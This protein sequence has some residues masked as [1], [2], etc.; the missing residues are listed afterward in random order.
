[1]KKV[2]ECLISVLAF[3]T[4]PVL[5][6]AADAIGG[7]QI[8]S[9]I[10]QI[11]S[12]VYGGKATT[13]GKAENNSVIISIKDD[14]Q[15]INYAVYSGHSTGGNVLN[16]T[17]TVSED[18][19]VKFYSRSLYAGYLKTT[20]SATGLSINGNKIIVGDGAKITFEG[21][22]SLYAAEASTAYLKDKEPAEVNGNSVSIGVGATVDGSVYAARGQAQ[23]FTENSVTLKG[24]VTG[25]VFGVQ[26]AYTNLNVTT[27]YDNISVTLEN[28][29]VGGS[30]YA[31]DTSQNEK[32]SS[33]DNIY[34]SIT[35]SK[36]AGTVATYSSKP[37][38]V[39]ILE[40][41]GVNEVG[42]VVSSFSTM[43]LNVSD[44]NQ[45]KAVLTGTE[46]GYDFSLSDKTLVINGLDSVVADGS[47]KLV[48]FTHGGEIRFN[49]NT[50][51][52][53]KGVFVDRL[54]QV[55]SQTQ[56]DS[57]TD[58]L[59]IVNGDLM[60][61]DLLI[62]VGQNHANT[63]SKTLA[64]SFLGSIAFVNQG[65]EFIADECIRAMADVAK[66]G[67]L[68]VFGAVHGGTS[69]YDTGSHVDVD[70]VTIATGATTKV[71][72]LL[73]AGFFEAGWASSD[74]HVSGTKGD[75]DHDYYGLGAAVRYNL[76]TPF[77]IDGS[78]RLGW[79]STEFSGRYADASAK[80]D[81]GGL[82]SSIHA[83][84]GYVFGL[85][86]KIAL[87]VYGRYVMTYLE[88]DTTHL[89]T[90]DNEK[91][92][93]DNTMTHAFRLG[94]RVNG[95]INENL[96]WRL[97]LAYERVVDG[98]AESD[99]IVSGTRASLEVPTLEGN[100]GIVEA[101]ITMR[102]SEISP[103]SANIGLKGYAGDREGVS[104]N[105]SVVYTF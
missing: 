55:D 22:G 35:D 39:G 28:A 13:G 53:K 62:S 85:T 1:M 7:T 49:K 33:I 78:V 57:W 32:T 68:S 5:S 15:A 2:V 95:S 12:T 54:W 59:Q 99:V 6:N 47:Y 69:R 46:K 25:N 92:D 81:A 52:S 9:E 73:L 20:S 45:T 82:Y 105:A 104:G 14:S 74:S 100:T 77:Y 90:P 19:N 64:E 89:D 24:K 16:N 50:Q 83:G 103:W 40:F 91:F 97:G 71:G 41:T 58:G 75:G 63:N 4:Y 60:S 98:D 27:A 48:E 93:M 36:I 79:A 84:M 86:E 11:T 23:S 42:S 87:D 21:G 43:I 8:L 17:L 96:L 67:Q 26:A 38:S 31:V 37:S 3:S 56:S 34:V 65:A 44:A 88:G 102:P 101:G 80:Y 70:G 72:D 61:G 10:D 66:A 29:E 76:G 30:V 18:S 94:A 51:I